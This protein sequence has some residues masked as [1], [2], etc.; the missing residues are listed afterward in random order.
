[1][2]N[3]NSNQRGRSTTRASSNTAQA[4]VSATAVERPWTANTTVPAMNANRSTSSPSRTSQVQSPYRSRRRSQRGEG[5]SA[6]VVVIAPATLRLDAY[7]DDERAVVRSD[8]GAV[9]V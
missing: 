1:M 5:A 2:I 9:A 3:P 6:Y 4:A 8:V 7:V